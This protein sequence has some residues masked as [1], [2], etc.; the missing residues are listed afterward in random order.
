M[1]ASKSVK[2]LT[3]T[4]EQLV[5]AAIEMLG[6]VPKTGLVANAETGHV[7]TAYDHYADTCRAAAKV[8]GVEL[9]EYNPKGCGWNPQES[10]RAEA[11]DDH[12]R[13]VPATWKLGSSRDPWRL[14]AAC[15]GLPNFKRYRKRLPIQGATS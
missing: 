10:R 9:V 14:C 6:Y 15:A 2:R 1:A 5:H 11:G 12:N 7:S 3:D 8:F 13:D 4:G